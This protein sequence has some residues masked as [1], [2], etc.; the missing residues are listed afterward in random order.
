MRVFSKTNPIRITQNTT[1]IKFMDVSV[2]I[3]I[4]LMVFKNPYKCNVYFGL[5]LYS[6][7]HNRVIFTPI[8]I[9]SI[10][11]PTYPNAVLVRVNSV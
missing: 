3:G 10:M 9:C 4:L 7:C 2:F 8:H 11:V 5:V 6:N 1:S